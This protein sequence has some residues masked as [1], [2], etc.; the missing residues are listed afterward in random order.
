MSKKV[1]VSGCCDML[2][3]GHIAFFEEAASYR[4]LYV[5]SGSDSTIFELKSRETVNSDAVCQRC[6]DARLTMLS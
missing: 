6:L 3:P 1:F 2:H 5:G 4:D